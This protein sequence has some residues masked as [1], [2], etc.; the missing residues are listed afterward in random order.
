MGYYKIK[1]KSLM[2]YII[3]IDFV[4]KKYIK[5]EQFEK[6]NSRKESSFF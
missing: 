1:L 5:V 3:S 2:A 6:L 4:I